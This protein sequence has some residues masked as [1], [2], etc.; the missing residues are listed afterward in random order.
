MTRGLWEYHRNHLLKGGTRSLQDNVMARY[1]T[2][3]AIIYL[4]QMNI[5]IGDVE[6]EEPELE[7]RVL[8]T[9]RQTPIAEAANR[10]LRP[11][12]SGALKEFLGSEFLSYYVA[13]GH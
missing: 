6:R 10:A 7:G 12:K 4:H 2:L 11:V 13:E 3:R 5:R 9:L 8:N 1:P